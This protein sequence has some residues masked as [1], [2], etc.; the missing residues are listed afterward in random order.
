MSDIRYRYDVTAEADGGLAATLYVRD[1]QNSLLRRSNLRWIAQGLVPRAVSYLGLHSET[2]AATA[3]VYA[4]R[5]RL[6]DR[7]S[8]VRA[9]QAA[10]TKLS[11]N[12]EKA[13]KAVASAGFQNGPWQNMSGKIPKLG[14]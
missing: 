9:K 6:E 7:V 3:E 13:L 2:Q 14:E 11:E 5:D 4:T 1:E 8:G 10:G 12:E